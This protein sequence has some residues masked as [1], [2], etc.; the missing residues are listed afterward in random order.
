MKPLPWP[1]RLTFM[2]LLGMLGFSG[3]ICGLL[4]LIEPDGSLLGMQPGWLAGSPF[5]DFI[6]PGV[7]LLLFM[8]ILPLLSLWGLLFFKPF[9]L[10]EK[11][12]IY[13]DKHWSFAFALYSVCAGLIWIIVQQLTTGYFWLQ[14]VIISMELVVLILLLLPGSL[15]YFQE[16]S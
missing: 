2:L 1:L 13:P 7:C 6:I 16:G 8:G 4:F 9:A 14:P 5:H 11:F 10:A 12:N 15:R 3:I